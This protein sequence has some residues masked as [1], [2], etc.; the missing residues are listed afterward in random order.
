[1]NMDKKW[2]IV[3]VQTGC[4]ATAKKAIEEKN[5]IHLEIERILGQKN[6]VERDLIRSREEVKFMKEEM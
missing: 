5:L 4:E 2:Y 1:M 3:N 6:A